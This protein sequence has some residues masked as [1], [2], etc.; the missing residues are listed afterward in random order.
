MAQKKGKENVVSRWLKKIF[1]LQ[2]ISV[3]ITAVGLYF[4]YVQ[5]VK[6]KPGE[7]RFFNGEKRFSPDI[8]TVFFGFEIDGDS[9][10]LDKNK[11]L[12]VLANYSQN[13]IVDF[14][15][16]A[17]MQYNIGFRCDDN[18]T[19]V[20]L[21]DDSDIKIPMINFCAGTGRLGS[22]TPISFPI[23]ALETNSDEIQV[24]YVRM[25]IM[26]QGVPEEILNYFYYLVGIPKKLR[27]DDGKGKSAEYLFIKAIRPY[28]L[29]FLEK[30][31][32]DKVLIVFNSS[33]VEA[34]SKLHLLKEENI[35]VTTIKELQ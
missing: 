9:I 25:G 34:P 29:Y 23:S 16:I 31:E 20:K 32:E 22:M 24:N 28:L 2:F 26:Y 11:Y 15:I 4:A 10:Y 21:D 3:A 1:S 18:Y 35:K 19:W 7:L 27:D 12:P 13:P 8:R 6:D 5:F 30:G 33:S 14:K 17:D